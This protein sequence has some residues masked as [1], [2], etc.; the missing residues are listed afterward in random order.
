[1][2]ASSYQERFWLEWQ[3]SPLSAKYNE[4]FIYNIKGPRIQISINAV[5]FFAN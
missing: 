3:L 5:N 1:M 4:F 2:K